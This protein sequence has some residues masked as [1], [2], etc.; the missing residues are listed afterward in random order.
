MQRKNVMLLIGILLFCFMISGCSS[1]ESGGDASKKKEITVRINSDPDFLDPHKAEASITD[2]MM[3][4]V[5]EGLMNPTTEGGVEPGIAEKYEVSDDGLIYTFTLRDGV[6]FHNNE[7]VTAEDVVYSFN[8]IT[9][10]ET[11]EPLS[12]D[13]TDIKKVDTPDDKTV[14]IKLKQPNSSFLNKLTGKNAAIIPKANEE[15][16]NDSPI[17]TGPFKFVEY[18]PEN[19]LVLEKF[20]DYWKDGIPYLDKVTFAFQVD[21]SSAFLNLQSG[22]IDISDVPEHKTA[23]LGDDYSIIEQNNNSV[24]LLGLNNAEKPFNDVKVRQALNYAID[25]DQIIEATFS[26]HATKVGSNMSPAMGAYYKEDLVDYYDYDVDK[27]KKLLA[28]AGYPDGFST[29]LTVSSHNDVYSESAQVVAEQLK[30]IGINVEIKVVEWATWL[31]NVY[32]DKQYD[33][34]LIDFTGKLDPYEILGRYSSKLS[35]RNLTNFDNPEY[36]QLMD[37]ALVEPSEEKRI[38]MYKQAQEI[39]TEQAAAVFICDYQTLW[40]LHNLEG[41]KKYP[42]F[43]LDMSE[44]KPK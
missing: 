40:G 25:K 21:D 44:I 1:K 38:D 18:N 22:Q 28:E 41:F 35:S 24:F 34:T 3:L 43:Y 16:H 9:G 12:E 30:K 4:N 13:F 36:D 20:D 17:G 32:T 37:D 31:E 26:G 14:V 8:R 15:H 33:M 29:T 7:P 2:R 19:N 42:I 5:F 27:A 23:E 6:K 39:L 11:G 10:K